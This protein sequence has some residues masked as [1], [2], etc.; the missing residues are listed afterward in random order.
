M[1]KKN[2]IQRNIIQ[3][4]IIQMKILEKGKTGFELK[5]ALLSYIP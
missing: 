3:R 5:N 2:I 1:A 4:N